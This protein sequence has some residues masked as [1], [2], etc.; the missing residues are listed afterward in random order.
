MKKLFAALFI[1]AAFL[2]LNSYDPYNPPA[3]VVGDI[4]TLFKNDEK[5]IFYI[6][7]YTEYA[8]QKNGYILLYD[9]QSSR[10]KPYVGKYTLEL[11]GENIAWPKFINADFQEQLKK[12]F[13]L[14][15]LNKTRMKN[16][17]NQIFHL[18]S[19]KSLKQYII[20]DEIIEQ[21]DK[22]ADRLLVKKQG[23]QEFLLPTD[24]A[25]VMKTE[26]PVLYYKF[27]P[28]GKKVLYY[29]PY[30]R[31]ANKNKEKTVYLNGKP[32]G[33]VDR[34]SS[35]S[36]LYFS[37]DSKQFAYAAKA[38]TLPAEP[39]SVKMQVFWQGKSDGNHW[40]DV[41][42]VYYSPNSKRRAYKAVKGGKYYIVID[43]K[44]EEPYDMARLFQFSPDS[45][46]YIY[47]AEKNKKEILIVNGQ[48]KE[49]VRS[50]YK[51]GFTGKGSEY[52]S[53]AFF[54]K[55]QRALRINGKPVNKP[56][57]ER[58]DAYFSSDGKYRYF[59]ARELKSN[60][61]S[62]IIN[63]SMVKGR[64][65]I[66]LSTDNDWYFVLSKDGSHYGFIE[67]LPSGTGYFSGRAV[68]DCNRQNIFH[69]YLLSNLSLSPNGKR[70]YYHA[71]QVGTG[72]YIVENNKKGPLGAVYSPSWSKDNHLYYYGFITKGQVAGTSVVYRDH[73]PYKKLPGILLR[74]SKFSAFTSEFLFNTKNDIVKTATYFKKQPQGS[75]FFMKNYEL[76]GGPY[77]VID[78][79]EYSEES[80][81]YYGLA[82][83]NGK[84]YRIQ[85]R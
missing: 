3:P 12:K 37:P 64:F 43:N 39:S 18:S 45:N 54:G 72:G 63:N 57:F 46:S 17:R 84:A 74:T 23:F 53:I 61:D 22:E 60:K 33:L 67:P 35:V 20:T 50:Y 19:A 51:F 41:H 44:L 40:D 77:H 21:E 28:D 7:R 75:E 78:S 65:N 47:A 30:S 59:L 52:Y 26:Q 70:H 80:G 55:G 49:T 71:A 2:Q 4:T 56:G 36:S 15:L 42:F 62:I 32:V 76:I 10:S 13:S 31:Y 48:E 14:Q 68:V 79:L 85:F 34:L 27:S 38:R 1:L 16:H 9:M 8:L 24:K 29:E 11:A 66:G 73:K 5:V 69:K 58:Y 82:F 83:R 6:N 81:L 25:P